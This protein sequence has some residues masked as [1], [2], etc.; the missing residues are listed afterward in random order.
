MQCYPAVAL[1]SLS[2]WSFLLITSATPSQAQSRNPKLYI[3]T[4]GTIPLSPSESPDYW[5]AGFNIGG[6]ITNRAYEW[7]GTDFSVS[8]HHMRF[9]SERY[10]NRILP[11]VPQEATVSIEGR[12]RSI[13]AGES[14]VKLFAPFKSQFHF[15]LLTGFGVY[16][17]HIEELTGTASDGS[18]SVP[19]NSLSHGS[20][21]DMGLYLG[22]G[23]EV[24]FRGVVLLFQ[25]EYKFLFIGANGTTILPFKIGVIF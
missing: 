20:E 9:D 12:T 10:L 16:Y 1:L 24:P 5:N 25:S 19:L 8:Y 2:L 14:H 21:T 23:F 3:T 13:F 17:Q 18:N 7:L 4:G 11:N 22:A 15:F 6:G